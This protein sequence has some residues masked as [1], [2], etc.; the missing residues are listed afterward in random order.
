VAGSK[1][2]QPASI[3]LEDG[4]RLLRAY[5]PVLEELHLDGQRVVVIGKATLDA[6]EGP[7]VQQVMAP[8]VWPES[9]SL[10]PL[11]SPYARGATQVRTPPTLASA[12]EATAHRDGWVQLCGTL[13]SLVV[14]P[15]DS[16]WVG[17]V[18]TLPDGSE[19][20]TGTI[21]RSRVEKLVG[22]RVSFIALVAR[23]QPTT[24][25]PRVE[26]THLVCEGTVERCGMDPR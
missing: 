23:E 3:V 4:T 1:R 22:K 7:N 26:P 13:A 18:V 19:I 5:R 12:K 8:H 10:D 15:K 21:A 14:D 17:M 20:E 9:V 2:L 25:R 24:G 11:E 6:D 16:F